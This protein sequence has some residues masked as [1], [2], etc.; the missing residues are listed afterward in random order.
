MQGQMRYYEESPVFDAYTRFDT[1]TGRLTAVSSGEFFKVLSTTGHRAV[2]TAAGIDRYDA[3]SV[4]VFRGETSPSRTRF[5]RR[6]YFQITRN[7]NLQC[8]YCFLKARG[9]L[10]HVPTEAALDAATFLGCNG[11][12]E[13]RLTGGEPTTHPDFFR[14]LDAFRER[15]V[16]VSVAT[17]G[18]LNRR[19]LDAL[20]ER[21]HLWVICSLD[22]KQQTH[23]AYRPGTFARILTNLK[24]LK[25]KQPDLRLRLTSVLTRRNK[26]EIRDL[27]EAA[28]VVDAESVTVIPLRPQLRDPAIQADMITASEFRR[29]LE[30]ISRVTREL[31]VRMTTT[32]ATDYEAAIYQDPIVRKRGA[33]AAGREATNL[34]YDA[35][36]E[37]FIVYGCSYSPAS[38]LEAPRAIRRPFL[39]G[40]FARHQIDDFLKIWQDDTAWAIYRDP[41]FKAA[42]CRACTY[43]QQQQCVGSC[44]I[45][46]VDYSMLDSDADVL[47]QLKRQLSQTAEWYCYQRILQASFRQACVKREQGVG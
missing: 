36:R 47:D 14:I 30:Q 1:A 21:Q 41:G 18:V 12:T 32:L 15:G 34:D 6:V 31:G 29:V 13:V 20:A 23:N 37:C 9:G 35:D 24:Y 43:F 27:A 33:C 19:T 39:A 22:G 28:R 26:E 42:E 7:C 11:L 8:P 3:G 44:P 17:N 16:Y 25:R 45:Q 2:G 4:T 38:D 46:N 5:P 40:E 10:P